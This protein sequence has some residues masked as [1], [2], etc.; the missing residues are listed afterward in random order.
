VYLSFLPYLLWPAAI[1]ILA[2]GWRLLAN[3]AAPESIWSQAFTLTGFLL[4]W[5]IHLGTIIAIVMVAYLMA[6]IESDGE[7]PIQPGRARSLA[8]WLSGLLMTM[9]AG[10]MVFGDAIV[11]GLIFFLSSILPASLLSDWLRSRLSQTAIED[12]TPSSEA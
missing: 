6:F 2:T 3:A 11:Q 5:L 4:A 1:V 12:G 9:L 10:R 7:H 8:I